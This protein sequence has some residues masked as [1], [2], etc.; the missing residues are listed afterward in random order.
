MVIAISY[1][2]DL[3]SAIEEPYW[4]QNGFSD[5]G[6]VPL[7]L[8]SAPNKKMKEGQIN[9]KEKTKSTHPAQKERIVALFYLSL[10]IQPII[11]TV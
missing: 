8:F 3:T 10:N 11:L 1:R 5:T 2:S 4:F 6:A 9:E 7:F